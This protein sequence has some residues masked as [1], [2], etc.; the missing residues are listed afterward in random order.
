MVNHFNLL[1]SNLK[2]H[3]L[4]PHHNTNDF[5]ISLWEI[6]SN[7]HHFQVYMGEIDIPGSPNVM[8]KLAINDTGTEAWVLCLKEEA[9]MY[10]NE[11]RQPQGRG[12]PKFF[13][14][15]TGK[16]ERVCSQWAI[17]LGACMIWRTV[18]IHLQS[19]VHIWTLYQCP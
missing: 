5:G 6:V 10:H 4:S 19:A 16:R 12:V 15:Y 1:G 18:V 17:A 14:F 3:P 9:Q 8:V 2:L 11:L 13:G 7:G